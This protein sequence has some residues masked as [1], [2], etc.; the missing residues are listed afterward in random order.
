[1]KIGTGGLVVPYATAI[2]NQFLLPVSTSSNT[3]VSGWGNVRP[4]Q[5]VSYRNKFCLYPEPHCRVITICIG[6]RVSASR[7]CLHRARLL[8]YFLALQLLGGIVPTIV[9]LLAIE[10]STYM[11]GGTVFEG[12]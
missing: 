3:I 8:I 1:M 10:L 12:Y 11:L 6:F 5:F 2:H 7:A 4:Y 9:M